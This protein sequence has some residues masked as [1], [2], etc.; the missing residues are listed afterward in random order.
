MLDNYITIKLLCSLCS[1]LLLFIKN[2]ILIVVYFAMQF[3]QYNTDPDV[4]PL[5]KILKIKLV[6]EVVK[7]YCLLYH[8]GF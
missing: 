1:L 6:L 5:F 4:K 2:F 8:G 3:P 7:M